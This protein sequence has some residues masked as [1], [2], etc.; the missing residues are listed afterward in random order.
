[1][2]VDIKRAIKDIL[3]YGLVVGAVMGMAVFLALQHAETELEQDI[4]EY[5]QNSLIR[6]DMPSELIVEYSYG[7]QDTFNP[8]VA[9]RIVQ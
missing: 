2:A 7:T 1:M 3:I 8:Q 4:A 9:G 5:N 6:F